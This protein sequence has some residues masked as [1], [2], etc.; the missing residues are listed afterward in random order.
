MR[1]A[2]RSALALVAALGGAACQTPETRTLVYYNFTALG[3]TDPAEHLEQFASVGGW[4]VS[5][6]CFVVENR[7][8]DCNDRNADGTPRTR[9]LVVE[10]DCPCAVKV[11]DPCGNLLPGEERFTPGQ[12]RGTVDHPDTPLRAGGVEFPLS[13]DLEPATGLFITE[14]PNDDSD[15][16]PSDDILLKTNLWRDGDVLRGVLETPTVRP[17]S[18]NV[19]VF[20]IADGA[21]L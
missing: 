15:P 10:C 11:E 17:I 5:L 14:E 4:V 21:N 2:L 20:H 9:P 12:I 1:R 8:L 3:A 6:G 18:G 7:Q 13:M 19:T 16:A